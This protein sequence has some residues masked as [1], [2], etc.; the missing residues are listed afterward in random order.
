MVADHYAEQVIS[1]SGVYPSGD[2]RQRSGGSVAAKRQR[3]GGNA[4]HLRKIVGDGLCPAL[5]LLAAGRDIQSVA[6]NGH[7]VT[8]SA[9][10]DIPGHQAGERHSGGNINYLP[11]DRPVPGNSDQ[12]SGCHG[13]RSDA[14]L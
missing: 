11:A 9:E 12:R 13:R 10:R 3:S 7:R 6:E 14:G 5:L 4:H 1:P 8:A 2:N